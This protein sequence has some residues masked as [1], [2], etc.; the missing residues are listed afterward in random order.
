MKKLLINLLNETQEGFDFFSTPRIIAY[1]ALGIAL[2]CVTIILIKYFVVDRH[3][4]VEL[5][6]DNKTVIRV[7]KEE[8][9]NEEIEKINENNQ[10]EQK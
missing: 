10:N 5:N 6:K 1:V 3:K 9:N 7:E 2:I 8:K 4:K